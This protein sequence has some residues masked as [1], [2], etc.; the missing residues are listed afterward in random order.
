LDIFRFLLVLTHCLIAFLSFAQ[1][2][3]IPTD[4]FSY[5]LLQDCEISTGKLSKSFHLAIKPISIASVN[6][7]AYDFKSQDSCSKYLNWSISFLKKD[8]RIFLEQLKFESKRKVFFP[9]NTN[10]FSYKD[11]NY[12]LAINPIFNVGLGNDLF[13]KA[14]FSYNTRGIEVYGSIYKSIGF[15][16]Y[17]TDN[18]VLPINYIKSYVDLQRVFPT[19]NLTKT[20]GNGE[21]NFLQARA[22]LSFSPIKPLNL[23]FGH[24]RHFI[25]D[26][27]RSFILSD[28][29]REFLFGKLNLTTPKVNFMFLGGQMM[30]Q[31]GQFYGISAEKKY[32]AF[33]HL[34]LNIGKKFNIGLFESIVFSRTDSNGVNSGYDFSYVNPL[35]FYRAV[36]HGLNSSDNAMIGINYKFIPMKKIM[37][38]GQLVLDEFKLDEVLARTGWYAN[39]Y[40]LQTGVKIVNP[41]KL[42]GLTIRAEYNFVRPY[43]FMHFKR[44]QSFVHNNIPLGHPL[45][46]NFKEILVIAKYLFNSKLSLT[47]SGMYYKKGYDKDNKNYGGDIVNNEYVSAV[48]IYGN[49]I[50]QGQL[51]SVNFL[52][53][54]L[55]YMIYHNLF[56]DFSMLYRNSMSILDFY[57][58]KTEA[59]S[60]G[61]RYN[62]GRSSFMML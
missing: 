19:A 29:G 35:V 57:T 43:T 59:I 42:E 14:N 15:Y 58:Y 5:E 3:N 18:I 12:T 10:M 54:N 9:D 49:F 48:T 51:V 20:L 41:F 11:S 30:N 22:Y 55:S 25:G 53:A 60:L 21:F 4:H 27:Y 23:Q 44:A 39:K 45:G 8:N 56:I 6:A 24:D 7:Y 32:F 26:G 52:E 17:I 36:E 50:G 46:A 62:I 38:Y 2:S 31:F 40:A 47:M 28:F 1:T 37:I 61:I 33:H 16:S 34:S 13:S